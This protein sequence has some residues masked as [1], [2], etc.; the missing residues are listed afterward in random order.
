M[1]RFAHPIAFWLLLALPLLLAWEVK[2]RRSPTLLFSDL[3]LI[4][5][6][7][8][9]QWPWKR[10]L[11]LLLRIV[12]I[13]LLIG[14]LARP[15]SGVNH[16]ETETYG[17][18][19]MM[20]QDVSGTMQAEDLQPNRIEAAKR[21][22]SEFVKG[23]PNDRIGLIV[24]AGQSFTQCPLTLDH[25]VFQSLLDNVHYNMVED[26][27][28][29]GMA[30][31]NAVNR[32][33]NSTAKSKLI[34]LLTDGDNNRGEIDPITAAKLAQS[35]DIKIYTIGIGRIGGA[36]IPFIH[37]QLGR[38]YARNP[39]GSL[40]LAT[41]KENDLRQIAAITGGQFYRATDTQ[42]LHAIYQTIDKLEKTE[43][44][45]RRYTQYTE[46]YPQWVWAG[47]ILLL[48]EGMLMLTVCRRLP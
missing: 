25:D 32:L 22:T 40:Q 41:M 39:D 30:I 5:R 33:R 23:R 47:L 21:V 8:P 9:S 37:P 19:I 2:G 4:T 43:I 26:G 28:A 3:D 34:I 13:A 45:T 38:M 24:F 16:H 44:K 7:N 20:V 11:P 12:A 27:T 14:A 31:A 42:S 1:F 17:V 46:L 10:W 6:L 48:I 29:I 18:D 15:Q 36:P 35:M